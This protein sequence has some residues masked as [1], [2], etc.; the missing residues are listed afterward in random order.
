MAQTKA[1]RSTAGKKAAATRQRNQ[2]K[3]RA[4]TGGTKA[5][6]SRQGRAAGQAAGQAKRAAGGVLSGAKSAARAAGEAT[7]QAEESAPPTLE[8]RAR[9]PRSSRGKAREHGCRSARP[10]KEVMRPPPVTPERS[11]RSR[12]PDADDLVRCCTSAGTRLASFA[13]Q[14]PGDGP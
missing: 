12:I 5:A 2:Q 1:D 13:D 9:A 14:R 10:A 8:P 11:T 6:A 3:Q 4:Q 7:K